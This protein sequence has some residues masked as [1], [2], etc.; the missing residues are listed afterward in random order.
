MMPTIPINH[1]TIFVFDHSNHFALSSDQPIE[2]DVPIKAKSTTS[3]A[4]AVNP[5]PQPHQKLNPL[6]K[7]LWTCNVE[8]T[9]EYARIV[10]DLFPQLDKLIRVM[11]TKVDLPLNSWMDNEQSLEHV[12]FISSFLSPQNKS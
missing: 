3:T 10:Y 6:V 1:K 11:I 5:S 7:S 2:F 12:R 8:A 9:L 4:V